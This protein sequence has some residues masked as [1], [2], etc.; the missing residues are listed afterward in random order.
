MLYTLVLHGHIPCLHKHIATYMQCAYTCTQL[1]KHN[2]AT[3]LA[4]NTYLPCNTVV[5]QGAHVEL[6]TYV[7]AD[8]MCLG[9][10]SCN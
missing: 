6:V 7:S 4:I 3:L 10:Q 1:D 2:G 5:G 8:K 9:L